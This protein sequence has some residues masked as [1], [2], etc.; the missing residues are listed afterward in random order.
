[1]KF[2]ERVWLVKILKCNRRKTSQTVEACY[3]V[4][5][6]KSKIKGGTAEYPPFEVLSFSFVG[7]IK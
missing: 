5:G 2:L 7:G 4:I 3:Y 6:I 1:M